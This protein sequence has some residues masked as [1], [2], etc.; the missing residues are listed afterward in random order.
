MSYLIIFGQHVYG[1]GWTLQNSRII[2]NIS[3]CD[4]VVFVF[5][6]SRQLS[7]H[8]VTLGARLWQL[9]ADR[10]CECH[11]LLVP[12]FYI[13]ILVIFPNQMLESWEGDM[14]LSMAKPLPA[15]L[16]MYQ[17]LDGKST[18]CQVST[19]AIAVF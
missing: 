7:C 16:H 9:S 11:E 2:L 15:G 6:R 17:V 5:S 14:V 10:S 4:R 18:A 19:G 13:I 3:F 8:Q 12:L 1:H